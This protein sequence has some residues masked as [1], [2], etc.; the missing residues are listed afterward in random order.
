MLIKRRKKVSIHR[1]LAFTKRV[2]T[3]ALQVQHNSSIS[4]LSLVR[5]LMSVSIFLFLTHNKIQ[6]NFFNCFA[7]S[8]TNRHAAGSRYFFW[9][10]NFFGR[11]GGA[12]TLQRRQYSS[13]G[14]PFTCEALSPSCGKIRSTH[15]AQKPNY[16]Q[17]GVIDGINS[18][19]CRTFMMISVA[20]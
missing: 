8:Q 4:L 3:L 20:L 16:W 9:Q 19:V 11:I 12:R 15:P 17:W 6:N 5:I 1:V 14:T 18:Q 13:L 10:R 7:D 2:S